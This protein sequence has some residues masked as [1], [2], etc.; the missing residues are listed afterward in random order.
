DSK[1]RVVALNPAAEKIIGRDKASLIGVTYDSVLH[2]LSRLVAYS[3]SIEKTAT[4][5]LVTSRDGRTYYLELRTSPLRDDVQKVV[6]RVV[7]IRDIT[8]RKESEAKLL[9]ALDAEKELNALRARF[10]SIVSHEFRTPMSI[11]QTATEMLQRY[12]ER[13]D[14]AALA[15]KFDTIVSQIAIMNALIDDVLSLE[16]LQNGK[17][18]FSP[19]LLPAAD[20][21]RQLIDEM[22]EDTE[23]D[24]RI[25]YHF[26]DTPVQ[27]MLDKKLL[28]LVVRNLVSNA[29]KYS[30]QEL[31][32]R[33]RLEVN[34]ATLELCVCDQGIGI[35]KR[36]QSRLFDAFYRAANVGDVPGSGLG[37]MIVKQALDLHGAKI[38]FTSTQGEGTTFRVTLPLTL[39]VN[40]QP[41]PAL[42][43][44]AALT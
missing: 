14:A 39:A 9:A 44:Q 2:E 29:L 40:G 23:V 24:E 4:G 7:V 10:V 35:P 16:R 32:V 13:M 41:A 26:P 31:P 6:G 1:Q 21:I 17:L 3:E 27:A 5:E 19:E 37:L 33:V 15:A 11:I 8:R 43:G 22:R 38:D 18:D 36:D 30:P 12:R 42:V 20:T 25:D 34:G 28:R